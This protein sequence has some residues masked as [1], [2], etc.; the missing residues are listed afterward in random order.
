MLAEFFEVLSRIR[1]RKQA[2]Q[3]RE[4]EGSVNEELQRLTG[5]SPE[6]LLKLS[7]AELLASL[8][9]GEPT[10]AVREKAGMV[11]ALLKEAGDIAVA[12]N[13]S[14]ESIAFYTKGLHLLLDAAATGEPGEFYEFVPRVE[15]FVAG[16]ADSPLQDATRARLMQ[17]YER[18]GQYARAEDQL[19][20]LLDS[21]ADSAAALDFGLAFYERLQSRTD[22][23]LEEGNLPR[24]EL[25]A[26]KQ[27]LTRRRTQA[28]G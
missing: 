15:V 7:D 17:H 5:H 11:T 10:L 8:I 13:R 20:E 4:A 22:A 19:Y 2:Q 26:G 14:R 1:A 6:A 27:E 23:Q 18:T 16:L 28:A 24:S 3:W 25:V 9:R 21:H 12:E